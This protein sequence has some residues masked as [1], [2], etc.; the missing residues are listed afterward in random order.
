MGFS[1][2][3]DTAFFQ[4]K[5]LN[6]KGNLLDLQSP[7]VMGILNLTPDSFYDGGKYRQ[8]KTI[9]ERA[10]QIIQQ[11]ATIID[12]GGYSSRPGAS[13]IDEAE[14]RKRIENGIKLVLKELPN[15]IISVDTFRASVAEAAINQGAA[16]VNDISGGGMDPEM[17]QTV[18]RLQIPYVLMHMKGTPQNMQQQTQYDNLLMET[19]DYFQ[20]KLNTLFEMGVKDIIIDPGFGFAK[21]IDQNYELLKNLN[22]FQVLNQPILAGISRKSMIY[23]R[24]GIEV[25]D[26]LNGT[27]VLNTIALMN[28]ASILRVHDVKQAVETVKLFK[29]TYR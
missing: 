1:E 7:V 6:I 17:F 25:G 3:K 21:T 14:E 22:Y 18:A 9:I 28:G 8:E 12:I 26:A 5:T 16:L 11:G 24:L 13:H 23:K 10:I 2:A 4:K 19:L 20:H 27:T 15:A 29:F